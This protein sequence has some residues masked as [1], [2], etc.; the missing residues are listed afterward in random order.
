MSAEALCWA[1]L[2]VSGRILPDIHTLGQR[3]SFKFCAS[4]V[5]AESSGEIFSA[6]L[7]P[8]GKMTFPKI[9]IICFKEST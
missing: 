6:S 1:S 9:M 5:Q 3:E 2:T 7:K 4:V 8:I